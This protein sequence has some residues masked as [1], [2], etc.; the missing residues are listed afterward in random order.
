M[1]FYNDPTKL[2][3]ALTFQQNGKV[4]KKGLAG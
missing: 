2:V 3:L 4:I 1:A